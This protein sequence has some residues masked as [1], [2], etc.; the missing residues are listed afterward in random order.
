MLKNNKTIKKEYSVET[1]IFLAALLAAVFLLANKMGIDNM[2]N[3]LMNTAYSILIETV[4]Y[5]CAI[6]TLMGALSELL[7]EFGVIGL[8]Q[9][10]ISPLM[11]PLYDMP[12]AAAVG[13]LSTFLSDNPA[14]L[15]LAENPSIRKY[16]KK[17][18]TPA[19]CNLGTSFGM[20]LIVC[21]FMIGMQSSFLPAVL[22]GLLGA[23]IGSIVSTR[24]MLALT[25][26]FYKKRNATEEMNEFESGDCP[27]TED[28]QKNRKSVFSRIMDS[29][30]EGG[31]QGWKM[32]ISITPGVVCICTI[33]MIFTF[34]PASYLTDGTPVYTG[35]AYEGVEL[36][37][38][39]GNLLLPIT[40]ILFGFRNGS[41]IIVPIT[42]LGAVGAAIS[43]V[44]K[45]VSSG[46][47]QGNEIAVFTAMG[48]CWSGYLSTHI[49][50][51]DALRKR[52]LIA[53]AIFSH[54]IGGLLAG[55]SAHF[56][57]VLA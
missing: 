4:L 54:T 50:M 43:L 27:E 41:A 17:Y 44:P 7:S 14:I 5:I 40:K 1:F 46:L 45:L 37:P 49:S 56:I 36:L 53:K 6:C 55:I 18:Q 57:Y 16:F 26:G 28:A 10:I 22:C 51:M 2:F 48:M 47:A 38:K 39:V 8:C 31:K 52:E 42:S 30:L 34:G 9:K 25:K 13:I 19:L 23:V 20:G 21:S 12:G 11:K 29:I 24:L 32:C 15:T 33:V 3:T 35:S